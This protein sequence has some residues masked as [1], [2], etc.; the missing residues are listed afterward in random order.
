MCIY[1]YNIYIYVCMYVCNWV[2]VVV[3][4]FF[5]ENGVIVVVDVLEI[6]KI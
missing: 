1:I 6:I 2:I 4:F 3:F 5:G